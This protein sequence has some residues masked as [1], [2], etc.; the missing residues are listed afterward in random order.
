[1]AWR[2]RCG[3][4]TATTADSLACS[5]TILTPHTHTARAVPAQLTQEFGGDVDVTG[6]EDPCGTGNFEVS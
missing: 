6:T 4:T 1:M 5:S 3:T 2:R